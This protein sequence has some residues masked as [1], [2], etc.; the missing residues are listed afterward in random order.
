MCKE[1]AFGTP[2]L[3]IGVLVTIGGAV[4]LAGKDN[5]T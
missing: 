2:I 4:L 5:P 3:V 1:I